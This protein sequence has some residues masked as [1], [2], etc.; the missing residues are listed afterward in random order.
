MY[1]YNCKWSP[2]LGRV[3][4]GWGTDW[5]AV[6]HNLKVVSRPTVSLALSAVL[7][8]AC[9]YLNGRHTYA[10]RLYPNP[11]NVFPLLPLL[12]LPL[13]LQVRLSVEIHLLLSVSWQHV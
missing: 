8:L 9:L 12:R 3:G 13:L 10:N 2:G 4:P 1:R 7:P 5:P 6:G 11:C